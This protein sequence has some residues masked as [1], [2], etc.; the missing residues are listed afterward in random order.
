MDTYNLISNYID[1]KRSYAVGLARRLVQI[2][3]VNPPGKNYK[4]IVDLLEKELK[5]HSFST[6]KIHTPKAILKKHS[7]DNAPPRINLIADWRT[8]SKKTLHINGHYDVVPVTGSWKFPPFKGLVKKGKLYGRGA[9]DMKG[10]ITAIILAAS[11]LK[12][13]G[14]TPNVNIQLS[15]TPDEEL[16]GMTG[17]GWLVNKGLIDADY[18]I[19]EGYTDGYVSC[20]NKGV[21][22]VN[23]DCLGKSAHASIPYKGKNSFDGMIMAASEFKKLHKKIKKRKTNFKMKQEKDRFSTMVMGGELEGG[24]KVNII[25]SNSSFSI[26]RR[27]IPEEDIGSA[28]KELKDILKGCSKKNRD[29]RFNM[30]ILTQDR[31]V[32]VDPNEKICIAI[33]DAIKKVFNTDARFALMP[34]GTDMR[35]LIKKGI[36]SVGYSA[37][38]GERWHSDNEFVYIKSILDTAKIYALT[39]LNLKG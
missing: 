13:L 23:I 31:A 35:Y 10:T 19:S 27:L 20:G 18:G 8:N 21:L 34:G 12:G 17:F 24:K 36:S 4:E 28:K 29:Y 32:A 14:L 33:G 37:K 1:S 30:K 6:R 25:P 22:W 3:T 7:I 2:P 9:E 11:A 38:G 15:F 39:I 26:D 5:R 16:G